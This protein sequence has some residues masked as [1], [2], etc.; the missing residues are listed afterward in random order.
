MNVQS[1]R[2]Y[3]VFTLGCLLLIGMTGPGFAAPLELTI[4]DAYQLALENN[5]QIGISRRDVLEAGHTETLAQ[6]E[7]LPSLSVSGT[8]RR[9]KANSASFDSNQEN[10]TGTARFVQPIYQGGRSWYGLEAAQLNKKAE[11]LRHF[12]FQ[13]E[14][15]LT[16]ARQFYGTLLTK[17]QVE[18]SELSLERSQKQLEQAEARFE[19]DAISR[20][21]VLRAEVQ[22]AEA[23]EQLSRSKNRYAVSLEDLAVTLGIDTTPRALR[24][25]IEVEPS[26]G[27]MSSYVGM[28]KSQRWDYKQLM[29]ARKQAREQVKVQRSDWFPD[30]DLQASG[31]KYDKPLAGVEED[32]NVQAVVSYPIFSGWKE[33]A[34]IEQARDRYRQARL[35]V[36]RLEREIRLQ[37]REAY[38]NIE[39][40]RNVIETLESQVE[41]A[42]ENYQQVSAQFEEGLVNSVDVSDAIT[43]LNESELRLANARTQLQ[44]DV[45]RLKLATGEFQ[46]SR[47]EK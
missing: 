3:L 24:G 22:V 11:K 1:Y 12:R 28:A 9:Q 18:L 16:V 19:V 2:E 20:T 14:I 23:R 39:T 33:E 25:D 21:P 42:R 46:Q 8:A 44:L 37:V 27:S 32:W 6:S 29:A 31:N 38:L 4:E 10:I 34:E 35:R 13:Q 47:I 26:L 40:Q 7:L 41:S 17:R 36:N 43:V 5:E 30:V 15:L 45:L